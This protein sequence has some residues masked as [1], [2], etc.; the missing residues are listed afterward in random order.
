[1]TKWMYGN[2]TTAERMPNVED[3]VA[4]TNQARAVLGAINWH[5]I[6]YTTT[7]KFDYRRSY[8]RNCAKLIFVQA[9][10]IGT[11]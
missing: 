7:C 4:R 6:S 11:R 2:C 9:L 5:A 10:P 1:M 8:V 3:T